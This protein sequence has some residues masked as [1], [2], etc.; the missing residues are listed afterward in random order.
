MHPVYIFELERSFF[1]S[2]THVAPSAKKKTLYHNEDEA[3]YQ[4]ISVQY[5]LL[6]NEVMG[7]CC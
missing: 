1:P 6:A 3:L 2:Q 4:G 7:A 5:R